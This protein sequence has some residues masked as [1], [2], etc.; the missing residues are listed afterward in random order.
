MRTARGPSDPTAP[1]RGLGCAPL[2]VGTPHPQADAFVERRARELTIIAANVAW[3]GF[4]TIPVDGT[5][6]SRLIPSH[7]GANP[8]T[9]A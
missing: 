4:G 2:A 8:V 9:A 5:R 1:V 7:P 6:V 3:L